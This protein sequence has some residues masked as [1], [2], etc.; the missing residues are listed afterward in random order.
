MISGTARVS[1]G[2]E[3]EEPKRW[4]RSGSEATTNRGDMVTAAKKRQGVGNATVQRLNVGVNVEAYRRLFVYSAMS[5]RSPCEI[6]ADLIERHL[7]D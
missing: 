1:T 2:H 7:K 5:K 6:V 3:K 4:E